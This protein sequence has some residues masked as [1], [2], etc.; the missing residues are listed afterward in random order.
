MQVVRIRDCAW[1]AFLLYAIRYTIC[2]KGVKYPS[3]KILIKP[4]SNVNAAVSLSSGSYLL[5]RDGNIIPVKMH[6][7][8][9][10][11]IERGI[12]RLSPTDADFLYSNHL[13]SQNDMASLVAYDFFKY[14]EDNS[15]TSDGEWSIFTKTK[16]QKFASMQY[17]QYAQQSFMSM[18]KL[19]GTLADIQNVLNELPD[20]LSLNDKWY[21]YLLNQYVKISVFGTVIEFRINSEDGYD[22]N[23]AIIDDVILKYENQLHNF[24]INVMRESSKGYKSYFMNASINDI[25]EADKVVLSSTLYKRHQRKDGGV[26]YT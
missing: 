25:L 14:V 26:E 1:P 19:S 22:W 6:A 13:I 20:P 7:P 3:M 15:I 9:T 10:D 11:Y 17:A 8:S 21:K 18:F 4:K 5:D 12:K 24:K 23:Q 16:Y 2:E